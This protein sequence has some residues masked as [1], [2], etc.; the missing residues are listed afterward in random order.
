MDTNQACRYDLRG[1]ALLGMFAFRL[2]EQSID[3]MAINDAEW[4][5]MLNDMEAK[6]FNSETLY[7]SKY[8]L[9]TYR[10]PLGGTR[11]VEPL[12]TAFNA[13][14]VNG[15]L[16]EAELDANLPIIMN[17]PEYLNNGPAL[18]G[19]VPMVQGTAERNLYWMDGGVVITNASLG[20]N[21]PPSLP[22][23]D[24]RKASHVVE[25]IFLD[26]EGIKT[27]GYNATHYDA[28]GLKHTTFQSSFVRW[29]TAEV[30]G[31]LDGNFAI[32]ANHASTYGKL[33]APDVVTASSVSLP[34]FLDRTFKLEVKT[35]M[36]HE[37]DTAEGRIVFALEDIVDH[38][39]VQADGVRTV[40]TVISDAIRAQEDEIKEVISS[41]SLNTATG[42]Q[43]QRVRA[44]AD[45][46]RM[47]PYRIVNNDAG[48][49]DF[50][51]LIGTPFSK[52]FVDNRCPKVRGFLQNEDRDAC[53]MREMHS[54]FG[55]GHVTSDIS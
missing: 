8:S 4:D 16:A 12:G 3:A 22:E 44:I 17:V 15:R 9:W 19:T 30:D 26:A 24:A 36:R 18:T 45:G 37:F 25:N 54:A 51:L 40:N 52:A 14:A 34:T 2:G 47:D 53:F 10:G 42:A 31:V 27:Y 20:A 43:L 55:V 28:V 49:G 29:S 46:R 35:S 32:I 1:V 41:V 50:K 33:T 6:F 11:Y 48:D 38:G 21:E 39:L 23:L 5:R 7:A 13:E